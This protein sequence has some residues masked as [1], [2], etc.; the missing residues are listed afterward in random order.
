[1]AS[2]SP[3][4]QQLLRQVGLDF[5][6]MV[7]EVDE[8]ISGSAEERVRELALCK[9]RAVADKAGSD[10]IV[11]GADTLVSVDGKVL[12]KPADHGEAF[13]MLKSLSGRKHQVYTGVAVVGGDVVQTFVEKAD[14][15]FRTLTDEEIKGYIS[16]GEPFDKA[17]GYGIQGRG[18]LLVERIEG[19]F[20]TV[21]GLPLCRLFQ[22]LH[23]TIW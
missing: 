13:E 1:L 23:K 3:R 8:N 17:G 2:A 22:V 18:A 11:I 7:S 19:D 5:E 10:V 6:V 14:V 12:E 15:F 9:A 21:M 16:T 4:R 20:Y